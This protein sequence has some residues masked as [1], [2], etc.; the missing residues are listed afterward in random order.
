MFFNSITTLN[1][2]ISMII[3]SGFLYFIV[4]LTNHE[5]LSLLDNKNN[6]K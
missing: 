4:I 2:I 6:N 5:V 1:Y 3:T